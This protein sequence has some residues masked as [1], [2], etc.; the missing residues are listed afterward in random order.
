MEKNERQEANEQLNEMGVTIAGDKGIMS[1][2]DMLMQYSSDETVIRINM[3]LNLGVSK[4]KIEETY[5]S[6]TSNNKISGNTV[7]DTDNALKNLREVFTIVAIDFS[8]ALNGIVINLTTGKV[9]SEESLKQAI[10]AG[11]DIDTIP[12]DKRNKKDLENKF[13]D[14]LKN[15]NELKKGEVEL[16]QKFIN[17]NMSN[18]DFFEKI[19]GGKVTK[20]DINNADFLNDDLKKIFEDARKVVENTDPVEVRFYY[21]RDQIKNDP[22]RS[23]EYAQELQ[24]IMEEHPEYKKIPYNEK[25]DYTQYNESVLKLTLF[26][27][28]EVVN[29]M[30]S[31]R[32]GELNPAFKKSLLLL[33]AS[34]TVIYA[35]ENLIKIM[36]DVTKKLNLDI[37]MEKILSSD[38]SEKEIKKVGDI[39]EIENLD[40]NKLMYLGYNVQNVI[41]SMTNE[42]AV[43]KDF[44]GKSVMEIISSQSDKILDKVFNGYFEQQN[45]DMVIENFGKSKEQQYF[46]NSKLN[47]SVEEEERF[48]ELYSKNLISS[49]VTSKDDVLKKMYLGLVNRKEEC[50]EEPNATKYQAEKI[51]W[52]DKALNDFKEK[53]PNFDETEYLEDGK[54]KKNCKDEIKKFETSKFI[55]DLLS[56]YV[57]SETTIKTSEDYEKLSQ[58]DKQKFIRDTL[59]GL[60]DDKDP[61]IKKFAM[62]RLECI[63]SEEK[64]FINF[65]DNNNPVIN[66][67]LIEDEYAKIMMFKKIDYDSI[68]ERVNTRRNNYVRAKLLKAVKMPEECFAKITGDTDEE[69]IF[70][71]ESLKQKNKQLTTKA[72]EK[73]SKN[74]ENT[75]LTK[76][77]TNEKK[78]EILEN[79]N[80]EHELLE[81]NNQQQGIQIKTGFFSGIFQKFK[82]A[83]NRITGKQKLLLEG[84]ASLENSHNSGN[85]REYAVTQ[86]DSNIQNTPFPKFTVNEKIALNQMRENKERDKGVGQREGG[87]SR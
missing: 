57:E 75:D 58:E 63:S 43:G 55:G 40:A 46:N 15:A 62:R 66:K 56:N 9:D 32:I 87:D 31:K 81:N 50:L 61:A 1:L 80:Q 19:L 71:I 52:I 11:L 5:K 69:K 49:W 13:N 7:I 79:S 6:I 47:L 54:L 42:M 37:S 83:F 23:A 45:V 51:S 60:S 18:K 84:N 78:E 72:K 68:I 73:T 38:E 20:E 12:F 14:I 26:K 22:L 36:D 2:D 21:L 65:D 24:K 44:Q 33:M 48:K 39:L 34:S 27:N 85:Q 17:D 76:V 67:A 41:A 28:L 82:Q 3:L 86:N 16:T 53:Y 35:D 77:A 30:D 4:D 70:Q 10:Q 8:N 29:K 59:V 74:F 64:K 25:K